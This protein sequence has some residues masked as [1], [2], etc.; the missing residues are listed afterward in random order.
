MGSKTGSRQLMEKAG[1]PVVPGTRRPAGATAELAEFARKAGYPILLKA[2]AGGG[3][4]GMRRVDAEAELPAAFARVAS[5]AEASFGDGARLR[6]EAR[7]A[8]RGTSR[9]RSSATCAGT[10]VAV[11]ERECSIQRRHQKVVEECPS[12]VVGAALRERALRRPRSPRRAPSATPPAARSSSCSRPTASFYFLEMNTRL[13]VEHP[14]TEE[15]WGVDLA[16][17]DDPHRPR[18]AAAVR[19]RELSPRA[20]TRSSAAIYAEDPRRGF[21]PS[22]GLDHRAAPAAG[23]G[24]AQR[25]R[26]RGGFGRADRLRPDAR[27]ADR[28]R[29]RPRRRR[30][31]ASSRALADYEIGGRRDDAAALPGAGVAIPSSCA[32]DFDVQWL[33][34]RLA[35]GLFPADPPGRGRGV[36]G[37]GR[38]RGRRGAPRRPPRRGRRRRSGAARPAAKRCGAERCATSS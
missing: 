33:D 25:R 3:G 9:S 32:G 31:R 13:Q 38:A 1:V 24:R 5:E 17:D 2:S 7:R 8:A 18:R 14:V 10:C 22:P 20:A 34:R 27:Q 19:R 23:P 28:P 12:P 30:S 21:A 29:A 26:R 35:A 11:G 6:R 37:R 15:V 4:K 36:A 16:G